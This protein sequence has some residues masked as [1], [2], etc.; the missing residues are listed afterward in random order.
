MVWST[1]ER[2]YE[3]CL[4]ELK[5]S[6]AFPLE[7]DVGERGGDGRIHR[8]WQRTTPRWKRG[9]AHWE[10]WDMGWYAMCWRWSGWWFGTFFDFFHIQYWECHTPNW[11]YFS[12]GVGQPPT[13]CLFSKRGNPAFGIFLLVHWANPSMGVPENGVYP[14]NGNLIRN[15][16]KTHRICINTSKLWSTR[17]EYEHTSPPTANCQEVV[18][19]ARTCWST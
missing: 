15:M 1:N 12:E 11:Q 8:G 2:I 4:L 9:S 17:Y 3:R 13:S 16:I 5:V 19:H 10:I 7:I 6:Q 14:P 18:L